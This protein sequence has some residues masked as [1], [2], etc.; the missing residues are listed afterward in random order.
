M[1]AH[2]VASTGTVTYPAL[3]GMKLSG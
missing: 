2:S 3:S 1:S